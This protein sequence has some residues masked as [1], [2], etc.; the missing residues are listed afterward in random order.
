MSSG[1]SARRGS[2]NSVENDIWLGGNFIASA[3][4]LLSETYPYCE[5]TLT[6]V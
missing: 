4:L 1:W 2:V 5:P 3:D 6:C